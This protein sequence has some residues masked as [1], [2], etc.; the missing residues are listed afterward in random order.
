LY[1]DFTLSARLGGEG[2]LGGGPS[3]T[4]WN[5]LRGLTAPI[6]HGGALTA[7]RRA[8]QDEYQAA[9]AVYQQTVLNAFSQVADALQAL[10]NDADSLSA[11]QRALD[12]AGASLAL[13]TQAYAAGN[14][15]YVQVLDAERLHQQAQLGQVQAC[16]QRYI[17]AVKLLL[18]VGGRIDLASIGG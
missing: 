6:F 11:Q 15:G 13:T 14:A 9:L 16:S 3:E 1:P 8:T 10:D 4:A 5:L 17:D 7:Q 18:A 12:S 2:L